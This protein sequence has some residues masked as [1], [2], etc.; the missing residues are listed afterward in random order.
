MQVAIG[1]ND[2]ASPPDE[3][4]KQPGPT[5]VIWLVPLPCGKVD[6]PSSAVSPSRNWIISPPLPWQA[7]EKIP[8]R[9]E[10]GAGSHALIMV[11]NSCGAVSL[12]P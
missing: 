12:K 10:G 9:E 8:G 2:P 5:Q 1:K 3:G 11:M 7:F 4:R 6:G